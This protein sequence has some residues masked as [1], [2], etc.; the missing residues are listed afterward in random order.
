MAD[1]PSTS[2]R[3]AT[4]QY[5]SVGTSTDPD[6]NEGALNNLPTQDT[7][8]AS[9]GNVSGDAPRQQQQQQQQGLPSRRRRRRRFWAGDY[10]SNR[11]PFIPDRASIH[12]ATMLV[13]ICELFEN[14]AVGEVVHKLRN[15]RCHDGSPFLSSNWL[16]DPDGTFFG[17]F[18]SLEK[19][20]LVN[21]RDGYFVYSLLDTMKKPAANH[22]V[23]K[24]HSMMNMP[25][26][27]DGPPELCSSDRF[28][29]STTL[30]LA[31]LP[32]VCFEEVFRVRIALCKLFSLDRHTIQFRGWK[33][34]SFSQEAILYWQAPYAY[35]DHF[36]FILSRE[37][38]VLVSENV[39]DLAMYTDVFR[40]EK[41]NPQ[42]VFLLARSLH[43]TGT[44][45]TLP[46]V[47]ENPSTVLSCLIEVADTPYCYLVWTALNQPDPH[48]LPS[49]DPELLKQIC[50]YLEDR[51]YTSLKYSFVREIEV[52]SIEKGTVKKLGE[53]SCIPYHYRTSCIEETRVFTAKQRLTN[54]ENY[55]RPEYVLRYTYVDKDGQPVFITDTSDTPQPYTP[56][57][58]K[59][60]VDKDTRIG[61]KSSIADGPN[62]QLPVSEDDDDFHDALSSFLDSRPTSDEQPSGSRIPEG[63]TDERVDSEAKRS[64]FD[65]SLSV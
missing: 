63:D 55:R 4:R 37:S 39:T 58:L 15:I 31:R 40:A 65:S 42:D 51:N 33:P 48:G 2:S 36:L 5:I 53:R 60:A 43:K 21:L 25:Q 3:G 32:G 8:Q 6:E 61:E 16:E 56:L 34:S 64:K 29:F 22:Y 24:F 10:N 54:E 44:L 19:C 13:R 18:T 50:T 47:V 28:L 14:R 52:V 1:N 45:G 30:Y 7:Q 27:C 26:S 11:V 23:A 35:Y 41:L 17:I 9:T 59:T 62:N 46:S 57:W 38:K 20:D 49:C 12:Y